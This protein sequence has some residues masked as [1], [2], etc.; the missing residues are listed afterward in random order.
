L[1]KLRDEYEKKLEA[2]DKEII[3]QI[4]SVKVNSK[5]E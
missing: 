4:S 2:K 5:L 3:E 1:I